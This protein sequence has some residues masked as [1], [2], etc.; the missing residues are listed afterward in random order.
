MAGYVIGIQLL[1][2]LFIRLLVWV[3]WRKGLRRY[4]GEGI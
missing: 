2:I 1:W 4:S 3:L